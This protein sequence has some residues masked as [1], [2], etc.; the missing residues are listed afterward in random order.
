MFMLESLNWTCSLVDSAYRSEITLLN[1]LLISILHNIH[2]DCKDKCPLRVLHST[3]IILKINPCMCFMNPFTIRQTNSL[4]FHISSTL[5]Y[6]INGSFTEKLAQFS[7]VESYPSSSSA[8]HSIS[9]RNATE[10][11]LNTNS[12]KSWPILTFCQNYLDLP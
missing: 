6:V 5:W 12:T 11:I 8:K 3:D 9:R 7:I 2:T 10:T 4:H 1:A